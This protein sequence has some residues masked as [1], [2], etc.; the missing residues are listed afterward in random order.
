MN[1]I[2]EKAMNRLLES[3]ADMPCTKPSPHGVHCTGG[4]EYACHRYEYQT[5]TVKGTTCMPGTEKT[6]RPC[7][8]CR[9]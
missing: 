2:K 1:F 7:T 9:T 8:S 4:G 3:L 5:A 6:L